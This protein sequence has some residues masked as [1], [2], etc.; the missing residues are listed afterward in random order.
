GPAYDAAY[1][2]AFAMVTSPEA[3]RA[4][5][6]DEEPAALRD[7]Y[8]RHEFG[9]SCLL[10]RRLIEAGVRYVQVNWSA[11][12]WDRITPKDDLFTRSTFDS[13]FGHFPWLRRQLPRLDPGLSTLLADMDDRGLLKKTLVVVLTEFGRS[14]KVNADG[15]RDH[16]PQAFTLLMAGAGLRGGRIV[17]QTDANGQEVTQAKFGPQAL[18]NS[19][20]E[21][22]GLDVPVT[23]RQAG[24]VKDSS[25][26]IPGLLSG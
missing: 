7:R 15:G 3:K 14:V 5:N 24:I 22:C 2:R 9:Q 11:R 8:G 26:G 19:I 10:G 13:H 25:E 12:G 1:E 23:L 16:W 17:G 18:L 6:V 4:F 20:Y 21:M